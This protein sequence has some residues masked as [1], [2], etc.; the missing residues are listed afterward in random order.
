MPMIARLACLLPLLAVLFTAPAGAVRVTDL[1]TGRVPVADQSAAALSQAARDALSQVL[2]KVSGSDAVLDNPII[3]ESL[4]Q[5][6]T[7]AQ[8]YHYSREG[9][10][11]LA[12]FEFDGTLISD[13]VTNAG[14]PLWTANRPAT[15]VWVIVD[16]GGQRSILSEETAPDLV[17]QIGQSFDRRGLPLRFPLLDLQDAT[18]LSLDQLWRLNGPA[19]VD[20]S[21]RYNLQHILAGRFTRLSSGQWLGDWSYISDQGR[22]D[23]RVSGSE[24][25]PLADSGSMLVAEALARRYAVTADNAGVDSLV[26]QVSGIH[27]YNSYSQLVHW[28]EQLELVDHANVEQVAGDRLVLRLLTRAAADQLRAT[29]ELNRRL[30]PDRAAGTLVDLSYRWQS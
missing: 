25:A 12:Q 2:V 28:L 7:L 14:E 29:I 22:T 9:D 20:A 18:R 6:Q 30:Q 5:A 26:M 8:Q 11:L 3:Q 17:E 16:E 4:G 19:L 24:I 27:D 1:Y 21:A 23:R 15:L 13:M 10:Q